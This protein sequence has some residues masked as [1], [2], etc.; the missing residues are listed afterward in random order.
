MPCIHTFSPHESWPTDVIFPPFPHPH[1]SRIAEIKTGSEN[2]FGFDGV[3][4]SNKNFSL[5][6]AT[7]DCAPIVFYTSEKIGI[8]HVGW[9]GLLNG[10][11]T[12]MKEIF[13]A[14]NPKIFI[15]PILPRFEIQKDHAYKKLF[16]RYGDRFFIPSSGKIF[17]DFQSAIA[18]ELPNATFDPRSTFDDL[19][20][21]S[22]RRDENSNRN[23]TVVSMQARV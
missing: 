20:L 14:E 11:I 3:W 10:I 13:S 8:V 9:R 12:N 22:W 18:L 23:L 19:S 7:A 16:Q 4:T 5:A 6:V 1:Q 15:G 2:L 21:A 17:F